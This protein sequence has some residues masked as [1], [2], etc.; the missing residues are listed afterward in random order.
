[1]R[2]RL[3]HVCTLAC[4][5]FAFSTASLAVAQEPPKPDPRPVLEITKDTTLDPGQDLRPHRH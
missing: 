1:M 2:C 4:L 3:P 5:A